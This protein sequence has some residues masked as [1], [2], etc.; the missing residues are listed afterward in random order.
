MVL[1]KNI[2]EALKSQKINFEN[3]TNDKLIS[4]YQITKLEEEIH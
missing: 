1:P 4:S 3:E 2:E